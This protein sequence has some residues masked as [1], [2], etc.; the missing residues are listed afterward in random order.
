VALL[1]GLVA[2][3]RARAGRE[4]VELETLVERAPEKLVQGDRS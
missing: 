3:L 2:L 1:A 4:A